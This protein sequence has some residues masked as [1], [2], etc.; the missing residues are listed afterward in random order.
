MRW[1]VQDDLFLASK[2]DR[3][4]LADNTTKVTQTLPALAFNTKQFD[5]MQVH[6]FKDWQNSLALLQ[7]K[8]SS[9]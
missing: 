8:K 4:N 5:L 2:V 3:R 9:W 1:V 7:G 6:N